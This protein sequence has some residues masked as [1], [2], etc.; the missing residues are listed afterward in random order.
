M[1]S[2]EDEDV[3]YEFVQLK[4]DEDYQNGSS[5]S[6]EYIVIDFATPGGNLENIGDGS[7]RNIV[8]PGAKGSL[9]CC[10]SALIVWDVFI[11]SLIT[12]FQWRKGRLSK[13]Y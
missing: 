1:T 2:G 6:E 12:V 10:S 5:G 13:P 7:S 3:E 11:L 9:N 8:S 4:D